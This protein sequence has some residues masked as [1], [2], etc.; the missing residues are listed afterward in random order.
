MSSFTPF[1]A[2]NAMP[3]AS[4]NSS[5]PAQHPSLCASSGVNMDNAR[6]SRHAQCGANIHLQADVPPLDY[7]GVYAGSEHLSRAGKNTCLVV[8][9]LRCD[10]LRRMG[11]ALNSDT[12]PA[13]ALKKWLHTDTL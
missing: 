10:A 8:L 9:V 1:R 3:L 11:E 2:M 4:R 13:H 6:P 5:R 12:V 7:T